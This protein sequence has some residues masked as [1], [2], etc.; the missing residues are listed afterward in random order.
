MRNLA[1][2]DADVAR[3]EQKLRDLHAEIRAW[4]EARNRAVVVDFDKGRTF[5]ELSQIH[6]LSYA[7]VQAICYRAGRTYRGRNG[8]KRRLRTGDRHVPQQAAP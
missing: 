2:I 4:H 5:A 7:T 6:K 8:V 1:Q 3:T